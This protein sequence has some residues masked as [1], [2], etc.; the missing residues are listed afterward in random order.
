MYNQG[1]CATRFGRPAESGFPDLAAK[2]IP[3]LFAFVVVSII[4]VGIHNWP[5]MMTRYTYLSLP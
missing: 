4:L 1:T 3:G 2:S 5:A